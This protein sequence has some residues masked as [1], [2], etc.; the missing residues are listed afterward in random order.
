[1]KFIDWLQLMLIF[2]KLAE[3]I[4]WSWWLVLSPF[5][6]KGVLDF[7]VTCLEVIEDLEYKRKSK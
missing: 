4:N 6:A 7:I 2:L 3:V 1:M 5:I